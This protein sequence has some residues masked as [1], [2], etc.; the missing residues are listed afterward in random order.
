MHIRNVSVA[1]FL[2]ALLLMS[3][4]SIAAQATRPAPGED[5]RPV[6]PEAPKPATT[7]INPALPT[8]FLVGDSTMNTPG[9][10]GEVKMRGWA[11]EVAPYFDASKINVVVRAIGGRSSKTFL[12]EGRWQKVLD[13][14][15]PGDFVVVQFGHNDVG[16][17]NDPNAKGR[18]SLHGEDEKTETWTKPDGKEETVHTFGWYMRNYATTAKAKG[19]TVIVASMV[20]HKDWEGKTLKRGVK[21]AWVKWAEN[22]AKST[23]ALY[24]NLNEAIASDYDRRGQEE[25]EKFFADRRTH[26]SV[27]GAQNSAKIFVKAVRTLPNDPLAP[28]LSPAGQEA[29]K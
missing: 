26:T 13:E 9:G 6:V 22:A 8:L 19:A 1:S 5:E 15:K 4:L 7:D 27:A 25:V 20:P 28:F 21:D 12:T 29:A 24:L 11:Q 10:N 3:H 2:S 18:P 16:R 14:I 17:Y 23:D